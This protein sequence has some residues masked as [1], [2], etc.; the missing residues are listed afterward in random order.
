MDDLLQGRRDKFPSY[1]DGNNYIQHSPWVADN[2]TGLVA[3]LQALA[4]EGKA[5]KYTRAHKSVGGKVISCW[6]WLKGLSE[7]V[8]RRIKIS[9]ESRAENLPSIGTP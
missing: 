6:S 7:G 8:A 1:F 9:T 2:L 4:K 3:G 5:V